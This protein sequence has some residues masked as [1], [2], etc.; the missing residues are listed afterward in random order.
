MIRRPPRSTRP[1]TLF[2]YTTLFRSDVLATTQ[3]I[4]VTAQRR[5]QRLMDVP[6]SITA[7]DADA[8][9]SQGV[10]QVMDL[11]KTTPGLLV[12]KVGAST[13]PA[14]RGISTEVASSGAD[15]NVAIHIARKSVV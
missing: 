7:L 1:D 6:A 4:V 13:V 5:S 11:T 12:S 8:L 14:I 15:A 3:D 9:E 10:Q 2:P